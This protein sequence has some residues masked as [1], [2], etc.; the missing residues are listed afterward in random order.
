[1]PSLFHVGNGISLKIIVHNSLSA[2]A[3]PQFPRIIF[4]KFS[5]E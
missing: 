3:K 5:A 4:G 1:M 2:I